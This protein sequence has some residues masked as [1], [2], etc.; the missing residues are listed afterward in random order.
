MG[1]LT[2]LIAVCAIFGVPALLLLGRSEI[3]RAL[4]DRIRHGADGVDQG[5]V[6]EVEELRHRL[7][8]VEDRLD[9]AERALM[10][11]SEPG[12]APRTAQG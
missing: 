1:Q 11:G 10:S 2:G 5:L 4:A 6:A 9:F 7:A 12:R 8:E 3:G